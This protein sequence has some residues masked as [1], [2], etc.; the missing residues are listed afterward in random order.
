[1]PLPELDGSVALIVRNPRP[2]DIGRQGIFHQRE[3]LLHG[4]NGKGANT[5]LLFERLDGTE[6]P[7]RIAQ[8]FLPIDRYHHPGNGMGS[9]QAYLFERFIFCLAGCNH[10]INEQ[11]RARLDKILSPDNELS[12]CTTLSHLSVGFLFFAVVEEG[13]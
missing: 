8:H 4:E 6:P 12:N 9:K 7:I 3:N 1:M 5:E 10:I 13:K 11:N 2:P